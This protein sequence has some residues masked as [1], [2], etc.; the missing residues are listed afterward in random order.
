M[1][2][3]VIWEINHTLSTGIDVK[4]TVPSY[5]SENIS[6][7]YEDHKLKEI[8]H[9]LATNTT[10]NASQAIDESKKQIAFF[11]ELLQYLRGIPLPSIS[12]TAQKMEPIENMPLIGQISFGVSASFVLAKL[13]VL[14]NETVFAL[15]KDRLPIWIRLANDAA[16]SDNAVHAIGNYYMICEDLFGD[17]EW[18]QKANE[19]RWTRHFVRHAKL[20]HNKQALD[21]IHSKLGKGVDS[22]D[23]RDRSQADFLNLQRNEAR[24]FIEAELDKLIHKNG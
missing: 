16:S 21:F 14:P 17:L 3:Q 15:L 18:P 10:Y 20:T 8:K 23:P 13:I 7:R 22:F 11:L 6:I 2:N 9:R 5:P 12:S 4:E 24:N 1:S 19:I